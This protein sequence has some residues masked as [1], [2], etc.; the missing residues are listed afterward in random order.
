[1]S[2]I[3]DDLG[4]FYRGGYQ[5]IPHNLS[6][7]RAIAAKERYRLDPVLRHKASG[8]LLEIGPWMGIF[9]CNAK[10]AGF[11]VTVIEIDQTCVD[12]LDKTLGITAIQSSDPAG[13][14]NKMTETFDVVALWHCLEHL[15]EPWLVL[16]SAVRR[17]APGGILIVAIP[18][19]ESYEFKVLKA[20]WRHI[21]APRHLYFYPPDALA[22]LCTGN[23]LVQLESTTT[24]EL[25]KALSLDAWLHWSASTVKVKYLRGLVGRLGFYLSQFKARKQPNGSGITAVF[26]RRP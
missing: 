10:D 3:P 16:Q 1:M 2:P 21:D 26:Q 8:K 14:M 9:I 15:R 6:Q 25:S 19:I 20:A 5:T 17:L 4:P 7:L 11:D 18:N 23:G 12:F 22:R 13:T 24:D